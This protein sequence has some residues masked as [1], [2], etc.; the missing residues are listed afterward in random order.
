MLT[1]FRMGIFGAA[2]RWG[3][4]GGGGGAKRHP[5]PK[6]FHT[7][8]TMMKL[9]TVIHYLKKIPK[10]YESRDTTLDVC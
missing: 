7:H 1:L 6:I 9:G 8:P 3:R 4:R 2:Y 10:I 5:L